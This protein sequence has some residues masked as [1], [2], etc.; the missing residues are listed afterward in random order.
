[1]ALHS[2][3]GTSL[4][5]SRRPPSGWRVQ[6]SDV[7][8]F[9]STALHADRDAVP[10]VVFYLVELDGMH[11]SPALEPSRDLP[12]HSVT[13]L[14][15]PSSSTSIPPSYC[16]ADRHVSNANPLHLL[17]R[18]QINSW[19]FRGAPGAMPAQVF[20]RPEFFYRLEPAG[21]SLR[22]PKG[23]SSL[24]RSWRIVWD[25]DDTAEC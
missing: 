12:A 20:C 16:D 5:Y 24:R 11:R 21:S 18:A 25:T 19:L 23:K 15:P 14:A 2:S 13:P 8:K 9:T 4:G 22:E 1:M 6:R 10:Y 7:A 17:S 3:S